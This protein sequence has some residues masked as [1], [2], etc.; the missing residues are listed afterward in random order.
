MATVEVGYNLMIVIVVVLLALLALAVI[1]FAAQAGFL[2][3]VL[4]GMA[5]IVV[6]FI[7]MVL[8]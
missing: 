6:L 4:A 2:K 5:F 1:Y 3:D 7:F 8:A